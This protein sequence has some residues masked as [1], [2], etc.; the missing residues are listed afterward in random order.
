MTKKKYESLIGIILNE[1]PE[2]NYP[3]NN[4]SFLLA[5][6]DTREKLQF[7]EF[8]IPANLSVIRDLSNRG[9]GD[10]RPLVS[11]TNNTNG[12]KNVSALHADI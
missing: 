9:G 1:N 8:I 12:S 2:K 7:T 5:R 4:L 3:A 10:W 6:N 11:I